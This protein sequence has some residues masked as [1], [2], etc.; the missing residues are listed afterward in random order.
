MDKL[1]T[2]REYINT[3]PDSCLANGE[4]RSYARGYREGF[5]YAMQ[6]I[7]EMLNESETTN[8]DMA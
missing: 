6:I 3:Y 2:I 7:R 5:L 8:N 1:Q 4:P